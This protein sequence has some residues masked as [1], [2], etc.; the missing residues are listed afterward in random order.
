MSVRGTLGQQGQIGPMG[1]PGTES[2]VLVVTLGFNYEI[3]DETQILVLNPAGLLASGTLTLSSN[4]TDGQIIEISST[5]TVTALTV[6]AGQTIKGA[7]VLTIG[8]S[9]GLSWR[10]IQSINTWIRRY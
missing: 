10:Y 5:Q 1:P 2:V 7:G 9:T 8:A 6:N 4:P 3:A